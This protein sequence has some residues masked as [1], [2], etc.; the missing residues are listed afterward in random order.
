MPII[1]YREE[2]ISERLR[3]VVIKLLLCA[4]AWMC[5]D[6]SFITTDM[7]N[8]RICG[9]LSAATESASR[10]FW[11][12]DLTPNW[13][14]PTCCILTLLAVS[15]VSMNDTM[16][17]LYLSIFGHFST[18]I[19]ARKYFKIMYMNYIRRSCMVAGLAH[20]RTR[21]TCTNVHFYDLIWTD[22]NVGKVGLYF[23]DTGHECTLLL[24]QRT[25]C[26]CW[27]WQKTWWS[28]YCVGELRHRRLTRVQQ[29]APLSRCSV[30][31]EYSLTTTNCDVWCWTS[32]LEHRPAST[33]NACKE[34]NLT[35]CLITVSY[36]F[37]LNSLSS[38][39]A[40]LLTGWRVVCSFVVLSVRQNS[41]FS[42]YNS[43]AKWFDLLHV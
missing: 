10:S 35:V 6:C 33:L 26:R 31:L 2:L 21:I 29:M 16:L 24:L 4:V 12:P 18:S 14:P 17:W 23:R 19:T 32:A 15:T 34:F 36:S 3:W 42:R 11:P 38:V 40:G 9:L 5:S 27:S 41:F 1:K 30:V 13:T 43:A 28:Y 37:R 39:L 22:N 7:I 20:I 25:S 8:S